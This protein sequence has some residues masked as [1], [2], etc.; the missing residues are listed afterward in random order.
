MNQVKINYTHDS[1]IYAWPTY[2]KLLGR[3][4]EVGIPGARGIGQQLFFA[5]SHKELTSPSLALG[6]GSNHQNIIRICL[7]LILVNLVY[8]CVCKWV[9]LRED[10]S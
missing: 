10:L 3:H 6:F 2:I 9:Y 1:H 4:E 7:G 8:M 5:R